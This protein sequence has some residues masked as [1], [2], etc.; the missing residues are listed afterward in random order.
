MDIT[1]TDPFSHANG[2]PTPPAAGQ[3]PPRCAKLL[4]GCCSGCC[5][6]IAVCAGLI[7]VGYRIEP[8][9]V[10]K[11]GTPLSRAPGSGSRAHG[12]RRVADARCGS[13]C[14]PSGQLEVDVKR[15]MHHDVS[16]WLI[17]GKSPEPPPRR[18]VYVLRS[19]TATGAH[20]A[21]DRSGACEESSRRRSSTK[22]LANRKLSQALAHRLDELAERRRELVEV[23]Q[24]RIVTVRRVDLDVLARRA[25]A[26]PASRGSGVAGTTDTRCRWRCRSSASAP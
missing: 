6:A 20:A 8:H 13:T 17:E 5:S 19:V 9:H 10:S 26:T 23:D 21:H 2:R 7:Y 12:D 22:R 15:G 16:H 18:A 24:E 4:R 3:H 1:F 11:D 14:C 25:A